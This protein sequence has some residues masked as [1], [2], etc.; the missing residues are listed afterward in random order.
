[1]VYDC[2]SRQIFS[3]PDFVRRAQEVRVVLRD[4]GSEEEDSGLVMRPPSPFPLSLAGR[5]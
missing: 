3:V 2:H 4:G 1:V 5:N